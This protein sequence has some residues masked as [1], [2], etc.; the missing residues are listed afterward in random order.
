[1][2]DNDIRHCFSWPNQP[3][4]ETYCYVVNA[5][6]EWYCGTVSID[7]AMKLKEQNWLKDSKTRSLPYNDN[8]SHCDVIYL[9]DQP[10]FPSL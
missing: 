1:M 2:M 8:L 9:P 4:H 7:S 5:Y 3:L 10:V 6:I